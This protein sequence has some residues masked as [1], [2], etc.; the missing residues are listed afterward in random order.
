[1]NI[2]RK[3]NGTL[4]TTRIIM[5]A[6]MASGGIVTPKNGSIGIGNIATNHSMPKPT[7]L[8]HLLFNRLMLRV[9]TNLHLSI[10]VSPI[11]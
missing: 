5:I 10:S 11:L 6:V 2:A 7:N 4:M 3:K 9:R 1:M 8:F